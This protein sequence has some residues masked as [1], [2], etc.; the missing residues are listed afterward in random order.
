M[1]FPFIV[2]PNTLA[3]ASRLFNPSA[4]MVTPKFPPSSH[5]H[6]ARSIEYLDCLFLTGQSE[7]G[8]VTCTHLLN[9]SLLRKISQIPFV[10]VQGKVNYPVLVLDPGHLLECLMLD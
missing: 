8:E 6:G 1:R 3:L 10:M 4:S 5:I 7:V 9:L 2:S